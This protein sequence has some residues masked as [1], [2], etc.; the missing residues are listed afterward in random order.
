MSTTKLDATTTPWTDL[1]PGDVITFSY[2]SAHSATW[3]FRGLG[4]AYKPNPAMTVANLNTD[5]DDPGYIDEIA[6]FAA[7]PVAESLYAR[8]N[9]ITITRPGASDL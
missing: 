4:G 1:Q 8:A 6:V 7:L 5:L 3:T 9:T 2:S